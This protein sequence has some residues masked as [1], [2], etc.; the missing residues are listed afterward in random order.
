MVDILQTSEY[1]EGEFSKDHLSLSDSSDDYEEA[2]RQSQSGDSKTKD[3]VGR[4][5]RAC[6]PQP[7]DRGDAGVSNEG[8]TR[9]IVA[10]NVD[11]SFSESD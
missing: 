7:R 11:L 5:R 9:N 2:L 6:A 3:S 8:W 10:P 1:D 4:R